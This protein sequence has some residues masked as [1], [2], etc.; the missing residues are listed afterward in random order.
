MRQGSPKFLLLDPEHRLD[1]DFL[2]PRVRSY[3]PTSVKYYLPLYVRP[4]FEYTLSQTTISF[5]GPT[6]TRLMCFEQE[7]VDRSVDSLSST[8]L[9]VELY[10]RRCQTNTPIVRS[11]CGA[12][13]RLR[14][15]YLLC[16]SFID[17]KQN[18]L[19]YLREEIFHLFCYKRGSHN[20]GKVQIQYKE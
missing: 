15:K 17:L 2:E 14:K 1:Q 7:Q 9:F 8:T 19:Y 3:T 18:S 5:R 16:H 13:L 20:F 11:F 12:P 4:S 6:D 10:I